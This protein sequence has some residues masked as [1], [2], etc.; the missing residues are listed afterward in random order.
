LAGS[1]NPVDL[2]AGGHEWL[3]PLKRANPGQFAKGGGR[4]CVP[5]VSAGEPIGV[6]VLGDRVSGLAYTM[7]EF[8]LLKCMGDQIA[9]SLHS[10]RLA[11]R[12]IESREL[13]A[14]QR[15][16][17]FFVHDLKNTASTLSLTL[18]N[19][20][21]HFDDPAFRQD[22]LRA[23]SKSV[24]RINHLIRSLGL[25]RQELEINLKE[26]DLNEL[27]TA[28]VSGL[29][30]A[31]GLPLVKNLAP[32]PGVRIDEDQIQKVVTNLI[33]NARD[34]L[35]KQGEVRIETAQRDGWVTLSVSDNGCGMSPAFIRK[36][37]FRPFQTT[38]KQGI[39]IGLFHSKMIVEAHR[40][41]IEVESQQGKGTTFR[42]KLPVSARKE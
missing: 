33:L 27:V 13:E 8:D 7:E 11:Q 41:K 19:L 6:I 36:S 24:A 22:A 16:S 3:E 32:L 26:S 29:E 35:G 34:A 25:L 15:M 30:S 17:A 12:L 10:L 5:L 28:T 4:V 14:F 9:T 2:D 23:I 42:V 18:Q 21:D 38:K 37:L 39:G 20:P 31:G 1:A 40:G